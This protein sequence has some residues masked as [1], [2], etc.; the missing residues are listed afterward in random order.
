MITSAV[1]KQIYLS[2]KR[3]MG[4][5]MHFLKGIMNDGRENFRQDGDMGYS[6]S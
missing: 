6:I 2:N 3:K 4:E 5:V 1:E